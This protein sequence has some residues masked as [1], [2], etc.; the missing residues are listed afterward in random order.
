VTGASGPS[1]DQLAPYKVDQDYSAGIA[2]VSLIS[3]PRPEGGLLLDSAGDPGE[4]TISTGD[5]QDAYRVV[6]R[7]ALYP[8]VN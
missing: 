4:F 6:Q 8:T 5:T 3:T 2:G 1:V 7:L